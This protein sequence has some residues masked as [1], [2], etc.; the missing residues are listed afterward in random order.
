MCN[1][2]V[3]NDVKRWVVIALRHFNWYSLHASVHMIIDLQMNMGFE[4]ANSSNWSQFGYRIFE[5]MCHL[6][7]RI[8][9]YICSYWAHQKTTG[10]NTQ[11]MQQMKHK[12][13][14]L[15]YCVSLYSPVIPPPPPVCFLRH[16]SGTPVV[17]AICGCVLCVYEDMRWVSINNTYMRLIDRYERDDVHALWMCVCVFVCGWTER[18]ARYEDLCLD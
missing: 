1:G 9:L 18:S 11:Y 17:I 16:W 13:S 2:S 8:S 4:S 14:L 7:I 10:N 6:S 3:K 12:L 15:F 5:Y